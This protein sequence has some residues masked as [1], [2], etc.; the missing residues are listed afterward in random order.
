MIRRSEAR[1]KRASK[2]AAAAV[3]LPSSAAQRT[4]GAG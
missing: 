3:R 4:A 1:A 2:E